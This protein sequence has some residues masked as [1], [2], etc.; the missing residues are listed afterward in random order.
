MYATTRSQGMGVPGRCG[1]DQV[2]GVARLHDLAAVVVTSVPRA[3]ALHLD[4]LEV[5]QSR[6]V[7]ADLTDV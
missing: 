3:E 2:V 7:V 6:A 4:R 5:E 1:T